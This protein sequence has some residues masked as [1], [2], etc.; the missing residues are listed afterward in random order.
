MSSTTY[1]ELICRD[2]VPQR[3]SSMY[4]NEKGKLVKDT[5]RNLLFACNTKLRG[6]EISL[7]H[8]LIL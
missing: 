3:F 2:A 4:Y 8:N 7:V 5:V 6:H 1:S